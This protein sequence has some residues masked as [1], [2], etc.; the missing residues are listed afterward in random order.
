MFKMFMRVLVT[1]TE[2]ILPSRHGCGEPGAKKRNRFE[3]SN[4]YSTFLFTTSDWNSL[5]HNP[6]EV[7]IVTLTH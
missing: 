4:P 6:H 2:S 1:C 5:Q 7:G 3:T